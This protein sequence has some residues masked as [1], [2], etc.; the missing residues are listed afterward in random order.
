MPPKSLNYPQFNGLG[1]SCF[2]FTT[3]AIVRS[4]IVL[5]HKSDG[6]RPTEVQDTGQVQG[7][8]VELIKMQGLCPSHPLGN[9]PGI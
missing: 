8:A 7:L 5:L 1:V 6:E 2:K 4:Q 3:C 9:G